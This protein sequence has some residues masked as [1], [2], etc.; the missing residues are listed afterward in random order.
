MDNL[1]RDAILA[2]KAGLS[3]GQW[4]AMQKPVVKKEKKAKNGW[5]K[6]KGCGK[7]FEPRNNKQKYCDIVCRDAGYYAA[8]RDE[9]REYA[10]NYYHEKRKGLSDGK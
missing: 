5:K 3:Y 9:I 6:C 1:A 10:R 4:K 8:H 2:K 7:L